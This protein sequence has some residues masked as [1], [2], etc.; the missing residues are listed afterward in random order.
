[1]SEP[2]KE[3]PLDGASRE[4]ACNTRTTTNRINHS[5]EGICKQLGLTDVS[6]VMREALEQI[7]RNERA[8]H[9]R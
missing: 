7:I 1:M 8:N 6:T 4:G 5:V 2:L 3:T 9:E